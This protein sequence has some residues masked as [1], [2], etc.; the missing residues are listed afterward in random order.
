MNGVFCFVYWSMDWPGGRKG[1]RGCSLLV[2][3]F[4]VGSAFG[5]LRGGLV[6]KG[7]RGVGEGR[8]R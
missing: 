7:E 3:S 6:E 5:G 8:G 2:I 4:L 1:V